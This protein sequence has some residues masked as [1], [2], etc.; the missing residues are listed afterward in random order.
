MR[1]VLLLKAVVFVIGFF[2]LILQASPKVADGLKPA[3]LL[4]GFAVIVFTFFYNGRY[5]IPR[6][7]D[8]EKGK[9]KFDITWVDR[10]DIRVWAEYDYYSRMFTVFAP[11][12]EGIVRRRSIAKRHSEIIRIDKKKP[13]VIVDEKIYAYTWHWLF[14]K[15]PMTKRRQHWRIY[16]PKDTVIK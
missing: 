1:K 6:L 16:V 10:R 2:M 8:I 5:S 12:D 14:I 3:L 4:T 7:V 15:V 9:Y 11:D 13:A